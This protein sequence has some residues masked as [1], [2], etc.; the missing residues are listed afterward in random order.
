[1][2]SPALLYTLTLESLTCCC[3]HLVPKSRKSVWYWVSLTASGDFRLVSK[4]WTM[5]GNERHRLASRREAFN[6]IHSIRFDFNGPEFCERKQRHPAARAL[7]ASP[8][9]AAPPGGKTHCHP[10]G[11]AT[12]YFVIR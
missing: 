6:V 9:V 7:I 2:I 1:M 11:G 4:R 12:R 3:Q 8:S 5:P 10:T